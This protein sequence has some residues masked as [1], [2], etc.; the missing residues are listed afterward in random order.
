MPN[1]HNGV[2][3]GTDD[4][5]IILGTVKETTNGIHP[6]AN[7]EVLLQGQLITL[8]FYCADLRK[9]TIDANTITGVVS[10]DS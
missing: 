4:K 3:I 8:T 1:D 10:G 2:N 7:V 9:A 6:V 5:V